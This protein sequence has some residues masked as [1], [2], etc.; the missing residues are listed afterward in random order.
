MAKATKYI[1][2][3]IT[4]ALLYEAKLI[5]VRSFTRTALTKY[6]YLVDYW[7]AKENNGKTFIGVEWRFHHYGPYSEALASDID[8]LPTLPF[9]NK[10]DVSREDKDFTLYS[11]GEYSRNKTLEAVG[12]TS[13]VKDRLLQAVKAFAGDLNGLLNF[14][15]FETEP[16]IGISPGDVL[17]FENLRKQ[18][19]KQD[20]KLIK[21]QID[22]VEKAARIKALV[23]KIGEKWQE[24]QNG[25]PLK[26]LPIRD[27]HYL[28]T[29]EPETIIND[30]NSHYGNLKFSK[31]H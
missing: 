12:I 31:E 28:E 18:N 23:S 2:A 6:L 24:S 4:E 13:N 1:T 16:M 10:V 9:I 26:T 15:Y 29:L 5:G 7:M 11:L 27:A 17:S 3:D 30:G 25:K 20:I 14:V 8:F 21:V 22:S 19:F